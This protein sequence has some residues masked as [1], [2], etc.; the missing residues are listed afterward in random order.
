MTWPHSSFESMP[1]GRPD[2]PHHQQL[3][4]TEG[5]Y[6]RRP[7]AGLRAPTAPHLSLSAAGLRAA[8]LPWN[9]FE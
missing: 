5:V 2:L 4:A 3:S 9:K 8:R 6:R 1:R 7:T